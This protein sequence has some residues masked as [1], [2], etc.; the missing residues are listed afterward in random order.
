[1][2]EIHS[3]RE[4]PHLAQNSRVPLQGDKKKIQA[5]QEGILR[6]IRRGYRYIF[7]PARHKAA[8]I[9]YAQA[10]LSSRCL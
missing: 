8:A 5:E 3:H 7:S 1:M 6:E 10:Y 4:Y 9:A 2:E